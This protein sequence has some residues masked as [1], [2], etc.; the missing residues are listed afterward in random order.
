MAETKEQRRERAQRARE[1]RGGNGDG[2]EGTRKD[3]YRM[4]ITVDR[5]IRKKIRIASAVKDMTEGE[6]AADVLDRAS[7]VAMREAR[8]IVAEDEDDEDS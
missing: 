6:W 5:S 7:T 1:A 8:E 2:E 3:V 4:S